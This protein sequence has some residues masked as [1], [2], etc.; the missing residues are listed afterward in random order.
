M[1][2]QALSAFFSHMLCFALH[3]VSPNSFP[4]PL[5]AK[6][7]TACFERMAQ[8]D[9]D[10]RNCLLV[11]N[12]RLVAHIIKN[13]YPEGK[14]FMGGKRTDCVPSARQGSEYPLAGDSVVFS[15]K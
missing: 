10:A 7:E 15:L 8:G 2:L 12:L 13:G 4:K 1:W 9:C 11:H 3:I 5:S 6:E 14:V